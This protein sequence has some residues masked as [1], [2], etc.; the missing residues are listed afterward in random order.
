M[1]V[2]GTDIIYTTLRNLYGSFQES[3]GGEPE[4]VSGSLHISLTYD[5]IAEILT[6]RLVEVSNFFFSKLF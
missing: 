6:V 4:Q 2:I 5:P 3:P 1:L